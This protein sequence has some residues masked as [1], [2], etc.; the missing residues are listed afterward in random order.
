[1]AEHFPLTRIP[2]SVRAIARRLQGAGHGA[3][4]VGGAI[5]DVLLADLGGRA[6][7]RTGD[8]DIATSARPEE[9]QSLFRRTVP[10]G[11]EHGTVAVLDDAN[12]AHEVTTFRRDVMTDGRHAVVEFGVS[13][14]DD[15]ARRDFTINAIAVHPETGELVDP[16]NGR[17]DLA[18]GLVRAVGDPSARMREDRLRVLRALRFAAALEFTVDPGTWASVMAFATEL[19]HLSRERVRDEWLKTLT[20]GRASVT[21]GLWRRAGALPAV[22]PELAALPPGMDER[23]DQVVD[24]DAVRVTAAALHLAGCES[25]AAEAAARRLRFP[26]RDIERI[27]RTVAALARPLPDAADARAVRRWLAA[28]VA[29]ADDVLA[30]VEPRVHTA[31][32]GAV[33][34]ERAAGAPLRLADLAVTGEDLMAAGVPAGPGLGA[35]LRRL[36][37]AVLDDPACNTR[38][39]LLALAKQAP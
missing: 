10:V 4:Y 26:N 6:P 23:L 2:D 9:V 17:S 14:E 28:H 31:L 13:L 19:D 11:I 16:F 3:W 7:Q 33:R 8:F 15:L 36:L 22:W 24:A 20:T 5:R 30:I 39:S 1:V 25:A 21:V 34:A 35:T 37:D 18:A 38:D 32:A 27:R 29:E 12:V